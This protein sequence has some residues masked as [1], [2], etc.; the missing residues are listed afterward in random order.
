[1]NILFVCSANVHRSKGFAREFTKYLKNQSVEV[2]SAGVYA[3]SG[4]GY[5]LDK[6][7][8]K[9]ADKIFVMTQGHKMFIHKVHNEFLE[10]VH[11]IGISDE[12]DID[13]ESLVE[14]AKYWYETV[15][16]IKHFRKV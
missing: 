16:L 2:R 8:L 14:V 12:Y 3:G 6:K 15:F 13:D 4:R 5:A 10:K 7:I 11:V 9:W 1:M